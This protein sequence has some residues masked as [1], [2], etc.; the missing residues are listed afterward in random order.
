M[1][2]QKEIN[3]FI[4]Y[5]FSGDTE[6]VLDLLNNGMDPNAVGSSGQT[7][8]IA[9]I[10]GENLEIVECLI[11][12]EVDPNKGDW[13]PLHELFDYAIDGMIQSDAS[14][15]DPALLEILNELLECGADLHKK[16][17]AGQSPLD[18][19]RTYSSTDEVFNYLKDS[20]RP[21]I[22]DIDERMT[23]K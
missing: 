1:H 23:V 12:W 14:E 6:T 9:A 3:Q 8:L 16:N 19:L 2:K 20:F 4:E 13:S 7:P 21:I 10:S 18:A 17:A 11:T 5:C 22:H 15:I